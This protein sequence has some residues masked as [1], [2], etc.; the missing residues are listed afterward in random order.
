[1]KFLRHATI[2]IIITLFIL[3]VVIIKS[4]P[5]YIALAVIT[6]LLLLARLSL[7]SNREMG[8]KLSKKQTGVPEWFYHLLNGVNTALLLFGQMWW[9]ATAWA[10]IWFLSWKTLQRAKEKPVA[11]KRKR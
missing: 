5:L 7:F 8:K 9:L 1:M 2:D 11:R 3:C 10:V 6:V 4:T